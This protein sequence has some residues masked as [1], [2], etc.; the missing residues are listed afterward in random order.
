MRKLAG[1]TGPAPTDSGTAASKIKVLLV[2]DYGEFRRTTAELLEHENDR[3]EVI[4][5]ASVEDALSYFGS[6]SIDCI[7]SDYEMPE[8]D[9]IEFVETVRQSNGDLPFILLTGQGSEKLASEAVSAGVTDY[10]VKGGGPEQ[11]AVL[12]NRIENAVESY[13]FRRETAR[14]SR[15]NSLFRE[16]NRQVLRAS[17][18]EEIQEAVCEILTSSDAYQF[19]W[20]GE[21]NEAGDIVPTAGGGDALEYVEAMVS[22]YGRSV[23]D[24]GPFGHAI[25]TGE[26]QVASDIRTESSVQPWH[27]LASEYGF[28]SMIVLP[29]QYTGSVQSV[30]SIYADTP[31]AFDEAEQAVLTE[32]A[33]IVADGLHSTATRAE[34]EMREEVLRTI[35]EVFTSRDGAL[36]EQ[37]ADLMQVGRSVLGTEYATLSRV[38][39]MEYDFEVLQTP[40]ETIFSGGT[41]PLSETPCAKAIGNEETIVMTDVDAECGDADRDQIWGDEVNRYLGTPLTVGGSIYGTLCFY[42]SGTG[43][44]EFSDWDVTLVDLLSKWIGNELQTQRAEMGFTQLYETATDLLGVTSEE[45][46]AQIVVSRTRDII[47]LPEVVLYAF[48]SDTNTFRPLSTTETEEQQAIPADGD[49]FVSSAFFTEET[50]VCD[51]NSTSKAGEDTMT[52][53]K[54]VFVPL[55]DHGVLRA[56]DTIGGEFDTQT[57]RITELLGA[58]IRTAFDR[59][60]YETELEDRQRDLE[61]QTVQLEQMNRLTELSQKIHERVLRADSRS[62]IE[63]AVCD[64]LVASDICSFAWIGEYESDTDRVTPRTWAGTDR[65]FLEESR[66]PSNETPPPPAVQT[67]RT[68]EQTLNN[69]IADGLR[70][71]GWQRRLLERGFQSVVSIPLSYQQLSYGILTVYAKTPDV[72]DLPTQSVLEEV[73]ETVGYAINSIETKQGLVADRAVELQLEATESD[74]II[75]RIAGVAD[76][77]ITFEGIVPQGDTSCIVFFSTDAPPDDLQACLDILPRIERLECLTDTEDTSLFEATVSGTQLALTVAEQGGAPQLIQSDG[78]TLEI[79]LEVPQTVDIRQLIA[80]LRR[81]CP[82]IELVGRHKRE[83]GVQTRESFHSEL[84]AQLTPRQFEVLLAAFYSG[85]YQSPRDK[86]GQEIADTLDISQPTF[87]H[88]LRVA[89]RK[90]LEQLFSEGG[91]TQHLDR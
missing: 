81:S 46:A 74:D 9:G 83:R 21:K 66:T 36:R 8:A 56:G 63:Q 65:G 78:E 14:L 28:R 79:Q 52:D 87:S 6:E 42:G 31:F 75:H 43:G 67:A 89:V 64:Q 39:G 71:K 40:D 10:F 48:D 41:I 76:T 18:A 68:N 16:I 90:L 84:T 20:I 7:V 51:G 11:Y 49:S 85:F 50:I 1:E 45:E 15:I 2:D 61:Q 60:T 77:E 25:E 88:H 13:R 5:A 59:L 57:R 22:R 30:I 69:N 72:F 38:N 19:A 32:L 82:D 44:S 26:H 33:E 12:T 73:S 37:I 29:I 80:E 24:D 62:E 58:T 54:A 27:E 86:T 35:T 70:G 23:F 53:G 47:G 4:E 17:T 55:G 34:L 3:I 91:T